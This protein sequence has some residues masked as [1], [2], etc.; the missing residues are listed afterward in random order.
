MANIQPT[1]PINIPSEL[2]DLTLYKYH[3][4]GILNL[5]LDRL[6][7]IYSGKIEIVDPNNPFMYLLETNCLNT[8]FAIQEYTLLTRKLYPRLANTENDLYLHMSDKDYLGRFSEPSYANVSFNILFNDFKN[9]AEYVPDQKEYVL[10]LPRHLRLIVDE[11]IFTLTSA[12]V[13]RLTE[14]EVIDVCS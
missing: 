2:E 5:A 14:T 9:K 6:S 11:Y 12:I 1:Q 4:N 7:E 13:I 8:A 3:S 10:K